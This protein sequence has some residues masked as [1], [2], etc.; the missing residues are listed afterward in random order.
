MVEDAPPG[1]LS[2]KRA[3]ARVLGLRTTHE[4][5]RMWEQGADWVVPDL[6]YVQAEWLDGDR[7]VLTI[8][9]EEAPTRI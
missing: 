3:G 5:Q 4:G 2:G 6:S 7:L 8:D 1:V 9:T